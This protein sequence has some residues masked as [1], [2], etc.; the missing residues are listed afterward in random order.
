MMKKVLLN[1]SYISVTLLSLV[2]IYV[3]LIFNPN[4][5]KSQITNYISSK[6]KYNF[7]YDGDI[8]ISYYPDFQVLMPG[9]KIFK[10]LS[11]KPNII[12]DVSHGFPLES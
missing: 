5:Y 10:I 6:T 3:F 7:T 12:A 9:I 4:D 11:E 1:L 2:I 8:E